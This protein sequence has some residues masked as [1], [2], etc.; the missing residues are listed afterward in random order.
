MEVWMPFIAHGDL[1]L[2]QLHLQ[3]KYRIAG[4]FDGGKI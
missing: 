3:L 4:N 2:Q 1:L